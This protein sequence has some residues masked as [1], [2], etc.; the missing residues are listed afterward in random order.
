MFR[1]FILPLTISFSV[2]G[3]STPSLWRFKAQDPAEIEL[4]KVV[5]Q[6][7]HDVDAQLDLAEYLI[8]HKRIP[9]GM[10]ILKEVGEIE[11]DSARLF[12]LTALAYHG[13][14]NGD[15]AEAYYVRALKADRKSEG[16][17]LGLGN[18][19]YETKQP[20]RAMKVWLTGSQVLPNKASFHHNLGN[21]YFEHKSLDKAEQEYRKALKI[22]PYFYLVR[23]K[24][25]SVLASKGKTAAALSEWKKAEKDSDPAVKAEAYMNQAMVHANQKNY[26]EADQL[27]QLAIKANPSHPY[28]YMNYA[29]FLSRAERKAAAISVLEGATDLEPPVPALFDELG[30]LYFESGRSD[31]AQEQFQR[32]TN[33]DEK[34]YK[35]WIHLGNVQAITRHFDDAEQSFKKALE[36]NPNSKAAVDGLKKVKESQQG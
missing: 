3:C 15:Q 18:L 22:D 7:E 10:Q 20:E 21:G 26:K 31:K 13:F 1:T 30:M 14:R 16:A 24:L 35:A 6:N 19:Y 29:M 2:L 17:Y 4:R 11:P 8:N 27:Y 23:L 34:F 28:P 25:G 5:A 12:Y 33:L 36:I 9:E 32:A